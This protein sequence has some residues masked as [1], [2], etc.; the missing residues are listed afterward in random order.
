MLTFATVGSIASACSLWTHAAAA[1]ARGNPNLL[2][3]CP[4]DPQNPVGKSSAGVLVS[5]VLTTMLGIFFAT[6]CTVGLSNLIERQVERPEDL[7]G[8]KVAVLRCGR[9]VTD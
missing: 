9:T 4:N 7:V 3:N 2:S 8:A 6:S 5:W 1:T